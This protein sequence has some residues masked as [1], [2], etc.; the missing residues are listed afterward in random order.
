MNSSDRKREPEVWINAGD[1]EASPP[2]GLHS[3]IRLG[4]TWKVLDLSRGYDPK[5]ISLDPPSIG[6]YNEKRRNMYTTDLFAGVRNIHMGLDIWAPAGTPVH[7]FADGR[8]LFLRDND[9]PGDYGPTIITVHE[10]DSILLRAGETGEA[11]ERTRMGDTGARAGMGKAGM[12][13]TGK[14]ETGKGEAGEEAGIEKSKDNERGSSAIL[15]A[16]HGHLSRASLGVVT[17]GMPLKKGQV[18][19]EVGKEEENGGWVPHLHFQLSRERPAEPDLPGVVAEEDLEE[20]L[21]RYP[22]PRLILGNLY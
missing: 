2:R 16:L 5:V 6:R 22:D 7:A 9:H 20:A 10:I 11:G 17:E 1:R 18:F 14:V 8:V 21:H 4:D 12:V 19:A 15:Y 13:E 3:V